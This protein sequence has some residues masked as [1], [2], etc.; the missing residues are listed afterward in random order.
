MAT[1]FPCSIPNFLSIITFN[2]IGKNKILCQRIEDSGKRYGL[3]SYIFF[4][5]VIIIVNINM[6]P[7]NTNAMLG[8]LAPK[9]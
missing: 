3:L 7:E 4:I 5:F 9:F 2:L 1:G 6:S 8:W